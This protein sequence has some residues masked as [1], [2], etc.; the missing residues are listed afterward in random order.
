VD[1]GVRLKALFAAPPVEYSTSPFLVWNGEVTEAEIDAHLKS[2]H[3]QGVRSVFIH[4]R[5]GMITP[6]LTDRWF[7]LCRH[8]VEQGKR[9]GMEVWLYDENSYPSGFAGGHVPAA[10][11]ESYNEGQGLIPRR[12]NPLKLDPS[13]KY[14]VVL[15]RQGDTFEDVTANAATLQGPRATSTCSSWPS[16]GR[17]AGMA[18]TPTSISSGPGSPRSSSS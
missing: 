12:V 15:R 7:E 16:M 5:P 18:A 2:F 6:Y 17:A 13:K 1:S 11:P 4:P 8:T 14:P 9:L 10:M 3:D